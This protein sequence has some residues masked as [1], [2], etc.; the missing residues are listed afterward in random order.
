MR[1]FAPLVL[2]AGL[3]NALPQSAS[4]SC[5]TVTSEVIVPTTTYTFSSTSVTT[6]HATT[7]KD[8]GTF[9]L[10]TTISSTSTLE[11]LTTTSTECTE[12]ETV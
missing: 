11:S 1:S 2:L 12:T 9:T 10:V 5:V 6:E 3:T 7:A 4:P 8:L